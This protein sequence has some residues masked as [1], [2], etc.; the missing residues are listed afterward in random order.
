MSIFTM[1]YSIAHILS[2]KTGLKIIQEFGYR[3]NW[4]F[5]ILLGLLGILLLYWLNLVLKR[6]NEANKLKIIDSL[7]KN[8]K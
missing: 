3:W 4:I 2:A 1:S 6:E 5:M 7:F 8:Q